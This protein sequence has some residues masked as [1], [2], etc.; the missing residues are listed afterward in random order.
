MEF[1]DNEKEANYAI[2]CLKKTI[3]RLENIDKA[4]DEY[5]KKES[6]AKQ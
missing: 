4:V 1:V 3:E 6:K 5:N 2:L